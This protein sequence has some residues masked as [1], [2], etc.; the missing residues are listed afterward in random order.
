MTSSLAQEF[1]F[2]QLLQKVFTEL[3]IKY[4]KMR[5][6]RGDGNCYYRAVGCQY[7]ERIIMK[8]SEYLLDFIRNVV[9]CEHFFL[10]SGT[11]RTHFQSHSQPYLVGFLKQIYGS[12][13]QNKPLV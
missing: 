3:G 10:P 11:M 8:G 5:K 2:N 7:L 9:D 13:K 1:R 6:I 12:L 4:P